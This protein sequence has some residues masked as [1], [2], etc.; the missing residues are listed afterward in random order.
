MKL[1]HDEVLVIE[2]IEYENN[3]NDS[4]YT[5]YT[6]QI[7]IGTNTILMFNTVKPSMK[8]YLHS[9]RTSTHALQILPYKR[10]TSTI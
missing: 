7:W 8:I 5:S 10:D 1:T 9:Q 3:Q 6:Q 2:Y 4:H